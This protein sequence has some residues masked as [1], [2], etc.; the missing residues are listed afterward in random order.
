[1]S[2]LQADIEQD[3]IHYIHAKYPAEFNHL[4]TGSSQICSASP[5]EVLVI[6]QFVI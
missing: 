5:R 1:L 4:Q 2:F 6:L 3:H